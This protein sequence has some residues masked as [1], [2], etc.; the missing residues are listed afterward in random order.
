MLIRPPYR[1]KK[2]R[3]IKKQAVWWIQYCRNGK[4]IRESSGS[5]RE[6]DA[7]KLVKRRHGEIEAGRPVGADANRTTFDDMA[8]IVI[9]DYKANDYSFLNREEDAISHLRDFFGKY[10]A[11][12]ITSDRI[13][14]YVAFRQNQ[15]AVNSTINS[16]LAALENVHLSHAGGQGG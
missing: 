7:W 13:T 11:I 16:E 2:T 1:D 10:R 9:N 4:P 6:A 15:E 5:T 12:E 14:A 8:T 3:E